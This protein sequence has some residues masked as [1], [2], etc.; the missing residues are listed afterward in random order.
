MKLGFY[1][2]L[3]NPINHEYSCL[4]LLRSREVGSVQIWRS[5]PSE[6]LSRAQPCRRRTKLSADPRLQ[7]SRARASSSLIWVE[8]SRASGAINRAQIRAS[9]GRCSS[10]WT[11]C[12]F[13]FAPYE[14]LN[15][16]TMQFLLPLNSVLELS[17][18]IHEL[19]VLVIFLFCT[20]LE[21]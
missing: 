10:V 5:A 13:R 9:P 11:V 14:F 15:V 6:R 19:Y 12:Y 21:F 17:S 8:P 2:K 3:K 16:P 4:P 1:H 18:I 7:S 20:I